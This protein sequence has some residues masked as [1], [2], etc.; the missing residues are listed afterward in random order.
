MIRR[1]EGRSGPPTQGMRHPP[2]QKFKVVA[3]LKSALTFVMHQFLGTWGVAMF[4]YYLG[5]LTVD[6]MGCL[7]P[8]GLCIGYWPRHLSFRC[9][10]CW[11]FILA[12]ICPDDLNTSQWFGSG[13]F[14]A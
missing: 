5:I 14:R 6:F 9:K 3:Y 12:G 8:C 13:Y 1:E 4:A 10:S 2:I 11:R 7:I